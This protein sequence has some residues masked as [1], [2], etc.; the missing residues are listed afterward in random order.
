M[1][2]PQPYQLI[3]GNSLEVLKGFPANSVDAIVTDSPYG[4]GKEPDPVKV[5]RDWLDHGYHEIKTKG[6]FMGKQWDNFVPQPLLW[7]EC[8][9]VLKP[10]G[11]LLSFFGTRTYDWGVMAIRLAGFSVRDTVQWI[12][13]QGFPKSLDVS[14]AIDRE[15][16]AERKTVSQRKAVKRMIPGADQNKTGWIK[17]NGREFIP[18]VTEAATEAAKQWDGWG[19]A[20]KPS[21]EDIVIAQKPADEGL[22]ALVSI[23]NKISPQI[24]QLQSFAKIPDAEKNFLL[25]QY[26]PGAAS[27]TAQCNAGSNINIPGV[28]SALMGTL[29]LESEINLSWNIALLW[30]DTL[31]EFYNL[32]S[33]CTTSTR[34]SLTIEL[35]ILNSLP[36]ADI[37]LNF[38]Q[39]SA[40]RIDGLNANVLTADVCF[41]AAKQKLHYILELFAEENA[42]SKGNERG[43]PPNCE[44]IVLAQKP[45]SEKTF[46]ANVLKWG[47]GGL[48]INGCRVPFLSDQ[49]L[50]S[51]KYGSQP[52]INGARFNFGTGLDVF[53]RDIDANPAGRWP[54]N[55][56]HD[57]SEEVLQ[58]FPQTESGSIEPHHI[59]QGG[60]PPIGTFE[61][62][63]R[64]GNSFPANAGSAA[65]FF[66]CGKATPE[67]R[68][69]GL[70]GF[71]AK[72]AGAM[73][74]NQDA[75]RIRHGKV[76]ETPMRKNTHPTVKPTELM[77]W[78][79]RLVTPPG[80]IVLDPFC[81]SGSTGKGCMYEGL[82]FIGI[83]IDPE[84][85]P[86][87]TARIEYSRKEAERIARM[88][89]QINLFE[90]EPPAAPL[91][92]QQKLF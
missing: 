84:N 60:L 74:G 41:S 58:H 8:Y 42:I 64:T 69:E 85:I 27:N 67:D 72:E 14:K 62:R 88:P 23:I 79:V 89:K 25:S 48:N 71:E 39:A 15:A 24:C 53:A 11:Y 36:L 30:L 18:T 59:K 22:T 3:A 78:L 26:E 20:L 40:S 17:D 33:M 65:R 52:K 55:V 56:V 66:Y 86:L 5:L 43:L 46:A 12:Y 91:P 54:A 7:K 19:T 61:I 87:A 82:R 2:D 92:N 50:Q 80:G 70:D 29:R 73:S 83:D 28:L 81:G 75:S 35:K 9:R 76:I 34:S 4:L 57:G 49:D 13:G 51:A 90:P 77:R 38:T 16:G 63:S 37:F 6:G 45:M 32:M 1:I 47:T 68:D 10:G 21:H 31:V 44:P